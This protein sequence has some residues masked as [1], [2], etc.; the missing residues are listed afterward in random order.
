MVVE[1]VVWQRDVLLDC[2]NRRAYDP[3]GRG[4]R[5]VLSRATHPKT[6]QT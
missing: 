6:T 1:D 3:G 5:A 2:P 4:R